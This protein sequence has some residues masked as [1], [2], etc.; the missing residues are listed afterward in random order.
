V[1]ENQRS[2][3]VSIIAGTV[4]RLAF[5]L[6]KVSADEGQITFSCQSPLDNG[7]TQISITKFN[8]IMY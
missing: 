1:G 7:G 2:L 6:V 5:N 8:G 3:A 4:P